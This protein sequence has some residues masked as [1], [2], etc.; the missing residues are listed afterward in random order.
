MTLLGLRRHL[1]GVER[2]WFQRTLAGC[3]HGTRAQAAAHR[4]RI[5]P[6]RSRRPGALAWA[7]LPTPRQ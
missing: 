4:P 3:A 1:Q 6:D 2:A 5:G 7:A